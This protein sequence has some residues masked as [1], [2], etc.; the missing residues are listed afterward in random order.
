MALYGRVMKTFCCH[1]M[2]RGSL[3]WRP[4]SLVETGQHRWNAEEWQVVLEP[5]RHKCTSRTPDARQRCH[6]SHRHNHAGGKHG[7]GHTDADET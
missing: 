2:L 6:I 1:S 3:L 7:S 5:N 4:Q